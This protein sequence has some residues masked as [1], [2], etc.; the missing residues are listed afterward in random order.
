MG[1]DLF[2]LMLIQ[3]YETVEDVIAGRGIVGSTFSKIRFLVIPP[4]ASML[5][6]LAFI[7]RKVVFHRTDREFLLEAV[8][9]VQEQ[10]DGRLD[11][12]SRVAD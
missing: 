2:G 10:D 11:E 6:E 9:L 3:G 12:P 1:V 4:V 7:V 8:D 5:V